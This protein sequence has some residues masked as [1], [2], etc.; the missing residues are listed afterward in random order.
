MGECGP[1]HKQPRKRY[2]NTADVG[3]RTYYR[4][5]R[6]ARLDWLSDGLFWIVWACVVVWTVIVFVLRPY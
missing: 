4:A 1:Q 6:Q 3:G 2:F 5:T